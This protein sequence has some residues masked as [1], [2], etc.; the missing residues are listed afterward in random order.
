MR[1]RREG[2]R[3]EGGGKVRGKREGEREKGGS[4][5]RKSREALHHSDL[6]I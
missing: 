6:R 3:E 2:E 5:A 4:P 1:G